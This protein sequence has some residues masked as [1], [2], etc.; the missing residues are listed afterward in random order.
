MPSTISLT[1]SA[2]PRLMICSS[3]GTIASAAVEPEAL[4]SRVFDVEEL[5][6][7]FRLDELVEDAFLADGGEFDGL[8]G[9]L[10]AFLDP[11]LLHADRK[12]A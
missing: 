10:D 9:T 2:P 6:E 11:R 12:Y 1:P 3:A 7:A 4:G 8:V 5:L